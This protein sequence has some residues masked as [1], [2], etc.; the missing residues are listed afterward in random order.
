MAEEQGTVHHK[1]LEVVEDQF[2]LMELMDLHFKEDLVQPVAAV[3]TSAAVAEE[4]IMVVV[5]MVLVE[6]VLLILVHLF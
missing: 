2:K 3:D 5:L 1:P 4:V 6:V